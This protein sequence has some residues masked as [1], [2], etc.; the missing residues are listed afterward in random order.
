MMAPFD[1]SAARNE[2]DRRK[3]DALAHLEAR[4][5]LLLRGRRALLLRLLI[6]GTATID[7]V[8][9]AVELSAGVDPTAFGA[10][11]GPLATAGIIRNVGY[12]KTCRPDAH[13]RPVTLWALVDR[14]KAEAWLTE[15]PKPPPDDGDPQR[16]LIAVGPKPSPNKT[17]AT[18]A[19]VAPGDPTRPDAR[20]RGES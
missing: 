1:K 12:A 7:D 19:A 14:A 20:R 15:H 16:Q 4:A 3:R 17:G 5:G 11:P 6:G 13:A 2:G 10:V 9:D 18:V 8:R